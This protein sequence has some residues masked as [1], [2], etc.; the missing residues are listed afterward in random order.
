MRITHLE[1][2]LFRVPLPRPVSLPASQD[3]RSATHVDL[4]IVRLL[5]DGPHTGLGFTYSFG[6]GAA[7]RSLLDTVIGPIVIG[8]DARRSEWL[9]GKAWAELEGVGFVGLAARAFAAVDVAV[10]DLKGKAAN[11]PI[12]ELLGGY[13]TSLKPVAV[14]TATPALGLK[15]AIKESKAAIDR[16][17]AG[18]QI[19]VGTVDPDLDYERVRQLRDEIPDGVWFEINCSSRYDFATAAWFGTVGTE[20]LGID[21]FSDPLRPEDSANLRR[22]ADRLDVGI[23]AGAML[24]RAADFVRLMD[25]GGIES[26]RIDPLRLGGITPVRRIVSAAELKH[27]A[28]YPARCPEVGGHF[29]LAFQYG[30]M[31]EYTDWFAAVFHGSP[32]LTNGQM[33]MSDRPGLGLTLNESIA[34]K[35]RV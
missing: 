22:L 30:R 2:D 8:L 6:G 17:V 7:M 31:C 29:G 24:D 1:T 4:V 33:V 26:V 12:Y 28:L 13:R 18:I 5:T 27:I 9:Y 11:A 20:E 10:W 35:W 21:G 3:P 34:A 16:G 15:Q 23:S 32:Q 25:V 19:E 14:D